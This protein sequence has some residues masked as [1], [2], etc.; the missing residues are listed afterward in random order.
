MHLPCFGK[1][2]VK[3]EYSV[4]ENYPKMAY[5]VYQ[6]ALE[7]FL[8]EELTK[9]VIAYFDNEGKELQK[10]IYVQA[11]AEL[12]REVKEA[13]KAI[14]EHMGIGIEPDEE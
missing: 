7:A 6:G 2:A 10:D 12:I 1:K 5:E 4:E 9:E 8:G 11:P 14:L 13:K 3:T